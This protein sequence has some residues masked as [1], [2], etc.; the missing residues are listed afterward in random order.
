MFIFLGKGYSQNN[1]PYKDK[2]LPVEKRVKDLLSRMTEEEKIKQLDMYR[3]FEFVPMGDAHEASV[4]NKDTIAKALG[5]FSVGSMHDFYPAYASLSNK[6]QHYVITHSRLGIPVL[7]IEEGLHG[8]SGKGSTSF[9]IPLALAATWDTSLL[10]KVGRTIASEARADGTDMILGPLLG[11][12]RDPRWG[13]MEETYGEDTYL[14]SE[15]GLAMVKG[16]QGG[17][18]SRPDAVISEPK[19]FAAHSIPEAG[20]NTAPVN[21]GERELRSEYLPTFE[22]A[23]KQG[24]ALGIMAAYHELDGIPMVDNKWLLTDVLR[25]QWGFKGMVV[26]DL[27]AVKMSLENHHTATSRTDALAQTFNAGLNMQFYD[28]PHKDF[29]NSLDSALHNGM[30]SKT[31]LDSA[32]A[33]VLRVKFLLGLFDNPYIDTTLFA[34]VKNNAAHQEIALKAAQESIVLLK[35]DNH[36]L[37]LK[38]VKKIAVIGPLAKSSYLGGYSNTQDTAVSLLTG[39]RQRADANIQ[40]NYAEGVSKTGKEAVLNNAVNLVLNSDVAVVALG[41]NPQEVG[42]G[43][44]RAELNLDSAQL[45]LIKAIHQTGKPVIVVLMNGR[46]LCVDWIAENIPAVVEEWF[47]GE[48]SGLAIADILLGNVNPSGKL[49]VTFPR[50]VGQIPFYYSHNPTSYHRYVD[51]KDTP[52]FPF[53][54]GLSYTTFQYSDLQLPSQAVSANGNFTISLKVKNTGKVSGDEIVQ[55]YIRDE[56]SSV[57]TP[58]KSLKAFSRATLQPG[59]TK[60]VTFKLNAFDALALWNREMKHVVEPGEFKVMVGS[61]SEDIRLNGAFDVAG[62]KQ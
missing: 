52:L 53:G 35:N 33:D 59:E 60:T 38:N 37:P 61:S 5:N 58:V 20:S 45:T 11:L 22:K 8:Y 4:Y 6:V 9:P 41:E 29:D 26:S 14:V 62:K 21:I 36:V 24:G 3:G 47:N 10:Y 17:D 56:V 1:L 43:K 50:S 28:F 32:V 42:E 18:V 31:R 25:K 19:H 49:P 7:F 57:V 54:H 46:A 16:L 40:I 23:V 13:R 2:K 12:A 15:I 55:L 27:G 30:L 48:K 34:K 44:D 39:L 51:E